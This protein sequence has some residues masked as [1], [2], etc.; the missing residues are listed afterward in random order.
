M[1]TMG[2][3]IMEAKKALRIRLCFEEQGMLRKWQI[4]QGLAKSWY[5]VK[6]HIVNIGHLAYQISVD[7]Q[8]KYDVALEVRI[9][10]SSWVIEFRTRREKRVQS[11]M[12]ESWHSLTTA[13]YW[14]ILCVVF[15][16]LVLLR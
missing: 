7:F 15:K 5:L 14:F 4:E 2:S 13:M 11:R 12:A 1:T 10:Q 8:L 9:P 16:M 3:V 6:P